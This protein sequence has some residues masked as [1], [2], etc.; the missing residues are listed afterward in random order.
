MPEPLLELRDLCVDYAGPSGPVRAVD[1]VSLSVDRGEVL[2]IAGESGCGKS[3]LAQAVLR[4]LPPPA[5]ITSGSARFEGRDLFEMSEPEL[6]R[7][8]WKRLSMVFQ[9]AL[10][11]LSPVLTLGEQIADTLR[12]H[13]FA[14]AFRPRETGP[15]APE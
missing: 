8:R 3:T 5:V 15:L 11:S 9:S 4:I 13:D 12:A 6:R 2:G 10:D 7:V 1:R 14:G